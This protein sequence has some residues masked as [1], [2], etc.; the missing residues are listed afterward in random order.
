MHWQANGNRGWRVLSIFSVWGLGPSGALFYQFKSIQYSVSLNISFLF[1]DLYWGLTRPFFI[2]LNL[3]KQVLALT[4]ALHI[5]ISSFRSAQRHNVTAVA[6]NR[7]NIINASLGNLLK[8]CKK[9]HILKGDP[10][11]CL[12]SLFDRIKARPGRAN[13]YKFQIVDFYINAAL[14][15]AS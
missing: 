11:P 10:R 2:N 7:N 8:K 3:S 6:P 5:I 9:N 12:V 1:H 13:F 14:A 4:E 15:T